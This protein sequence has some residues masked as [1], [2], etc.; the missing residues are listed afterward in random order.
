MSLN[1]LIGTWA[2]PYEPGTGYVMAHHSI[3]DVGDGNLGAWAV[4]E[5][6]MGA[7]AAAIESSA[8]TF[9]AEIRTNARVAR[10]LTAQGRGTRRRARGGRGARSRRCRHGDPSEDHVPAA[11]RPDRAAGGLRARHRALELAQ[12]RR[13][14]QLRARPAPGLHVEAGAHGPVRAA[15]S[16]RT[17]SRTWR[18]RSRRRARGGRRRCR[19]RDGVVPTSLDPSLAPEGKHVISLFTQ[20]V[21]A[22]V[23]RGAAPRGARGVRRPRD[24]RLRRAGSRVRATASCT[25]R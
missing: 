15:S 21:P 20:W 22:R 25:A 17:R 4:P 24:R 6:G 7:V 10:I 3:G 12:R 16:W 2:G 1:G 13:E 18:R 19:S 8:R 23:E 11:A 14:D 9:G 5:G